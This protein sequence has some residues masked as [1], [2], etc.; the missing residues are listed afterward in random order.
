[1]HTA[2]KA[3]TFDFRRAAACAALALLTTL[4]T[5]SLIANV[6]PPLIADG[7]ILASSHETVCAPTAQ[8]LEAADHARRSVI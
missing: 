3:S 5:F 2:M 7:L 8:V 4:G 1:M 6:M